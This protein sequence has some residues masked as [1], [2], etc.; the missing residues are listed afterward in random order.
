MWFKK[1]NT[2]EITISDNTVRWRIQFYGRVQN[3]GF[4]FTACQI[5]EQLGLTGWVRNELDGSVTLEIQGE[6]EKLNQVIGLLYED[7]Y[8]RIDDYKIQSLKVVPNENRFSY[9]Y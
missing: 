4:R 3:V 5:A 7:K 1:K 2:K 8:I 6:V 9:Q